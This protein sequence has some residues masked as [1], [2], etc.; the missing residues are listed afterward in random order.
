MT[1]SV[2]DQQLVAS[3]RAR[4]LTIKRRRRAAHAVFYESRRYRRGLTALAALLVACSVAAIFVSEASTHSDWL[5][6]WRA[7]LVLVAVG[8]LVGALLGQGLLGTG[9]GRRLLANKERRLNQKYSGDLHAGRRWLQFY[10]QGEDIAC[11]VPQVLYVIESEHRFDSVPEALAFVKQH[12]HEN[13]S[14]QARAL[15]RFNAIAAQ[16]NLAVVSSVNVHGQPSSRVMRFVRTDRPGLWY[17]T[18]APGTPKVPEFDTGKIALITVPTANSA[19]ISSNRV[20]ISRAEKTFSDIADLYRTQVPGYLDGM[21]EEDQ[22]LELVYE[23]R[24]QS[25]KV[26]TWISND[27]V[28]LRELNES[29]D[30]DANARL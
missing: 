6:Q 22:R 8:A 15:E 19:T 17:A 3:M 10:Y 24:L 13:T 7:K 4:E 16:T 26:D 18:T 29:S 1:L 11:Y 23:L 25:A 28:S 14:A 12:H 30:K 2:E 9:L 21:T 27:L 20:R 5:N